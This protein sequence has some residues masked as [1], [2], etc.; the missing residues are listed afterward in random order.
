MEY[1]SISKLLKEYETALHGREIERNLY[2]TKLTH[3]NIKKF[4]TYAN[5]LKLEETTRITNQRKDKFIDEEELL[6]TNSN[7]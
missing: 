1:N 3:K 6:K 4:K 7:Y 2:L 5:K